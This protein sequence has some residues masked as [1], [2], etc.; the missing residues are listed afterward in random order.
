MEDQEGEQNKNKSTQGRTMRSSKRRNSDP[1]PARQVKQKFDDNHKMAL[2]LE[3]LRAELATMD[4][5]ITKNT[6][7]SLI[8][9]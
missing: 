6:D 7:L 5:K 9:I 4:Q 3:Q 1:I 2:T 8:H